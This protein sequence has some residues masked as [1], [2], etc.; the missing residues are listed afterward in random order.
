LYTWKGREKGR[1]R[2]HQF[3]HSIKG[4]KGRER[5]TGRRRTKR[6]S[7]VYFFFAR[8]GEEGKVAEGKLQLWKLEKEGN[9]TNKSVEKA[10]CPIIEHIMQS[11]DPLEKRKR[12]PTPMS[13]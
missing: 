12:K 1:I 3:L 6:A 4:G 2:S 11:K 8:K 9:E 13:S 5:P 7:N 10:K